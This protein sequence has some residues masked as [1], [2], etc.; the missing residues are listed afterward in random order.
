MQARYEIT[1][2][3]TICQELDSV[4]EVINADDVATAAASAICDELTNFNAVTVFEVTENTI[5]IK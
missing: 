5:E 2:K 1:V 4:K 3:F